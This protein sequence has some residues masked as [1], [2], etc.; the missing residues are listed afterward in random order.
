[1]SSL[2]KY[3]LVGL[4]GFCIDFSFFKLLF[5]VLPTALEARLLSWLFAV[6]FTY[7]GNSA[8]TF[9]RS[10][11]TSHFPGVSHLRLLLG[12]R[13]VVLRGVRKIVRQPISQFFLY[14]SSQFLGGTINISVFSFSY[15]ILFGG[16]NQFIAFVVGTIAGLVVNYFGAK[17]SI[18]SS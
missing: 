11:G 1:M 12:A 4:V 9:S 5:V 18:G 3:A 13:V 7:C 16:H 14:V 8:F 17:L 2:Y 15:F 6:F 10:S